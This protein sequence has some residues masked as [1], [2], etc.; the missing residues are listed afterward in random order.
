MA[1]QPDKSKPSKSA[2]EPLPAAC[3]VVDCSTGQ[4]RF[5][6]FAGGKHQMKLVDVRETGLEEKIPE[7]HLDRDASQMWRAHCQNDAWLPVDKVYFRVLQLPMCDARE[8]PGMVELQLEK[9]SPLALG[10]AVWSFEVVPAHRPG[11]EQQTVVVMLAERAVV[12]QAV[13]E[14]EQAGYFPDRMEAAVLHQ[15]LAT[16][17]GG[18]CPDGAW[19]YPAFLEERVVCTVAWWDEGVLQNITQI[20]LSSD[21]HLNELTEQLT[22]ATW[23]GEMEGWLTGT[24]HWHL[25]MEAETGER[26][27]P[28]LNEW[29]GQSME[30]RPPLDD[31]ALAAL[32]A[33]RAGRPLE[34]GNL[35]PPERRVRYHRDDVD[36]GLGGIFT[37][38]LLLYAMLMAGYFVLNTQTA[39]EEEAR[40]QEKKKLEK[41][42]KEFKKLQDKHDLLIL[43][44]N[45]RMTALQVLKEVAAQMPE[46]LTLRSINFT[47]NTRDGGNTVVIM[48][49]GRVEPGQGNKVSDYRDNMTR[50]TIRDPITN[51]NRNLFS[52]V[53]SPNTRLTAGGAEAPM[54]WD[55]SCVLQTGLMKQ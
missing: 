15:V 21:E 33:G 36:R 14:L 7:K 2:A 37:W 47:E 54:E 46:E 18:E 35:L 12:E 1:D 44:R 48:L 26:W 32:C 27:L 39:R 30:A 4:Q 50:V 53:N 13:G 16:P 49:R 19:I 52:Q 10:Q 45:S 43:Q 38:I 5:W 42:E 6:R 29:A 22:A 9:I 55:M 28:V 3:N 17:Q 31:S 11:R 41:L 8:L 40:Y 25:V 23:A 34:Q 20:T 24:T 51:E